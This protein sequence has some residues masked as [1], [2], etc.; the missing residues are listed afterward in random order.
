[1]RYPGAIS[2]VVQS[3]SHHF[4]FVGSE[5]P[6]LPVDGQVQTGPAIRLVM[7]LQQ[8]GTGAA[9]RIV[10]RLVA[11]RGAGY[12]D[13]LGNHAG[14]FGRRIKLTLALATHGGEVPHQDS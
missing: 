1:M 8:Q 2:A 6:V 14:D 9:G 11:P 13:H 12:A 4:I 5:S 3:C 7:R 10:D